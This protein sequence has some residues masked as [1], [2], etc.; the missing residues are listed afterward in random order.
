MSVPQIDVQDN[1]I[2]PT[3]MT[4][5]E[6]LTYRNLIEAM[7]FIPEPKPGEENYRTTLAMIITIHEQMKNRVTSESDLMELTQV[8]YIARKASTETKAIRLQPLLS[9]L[10]KV[11]E[12]LQPTE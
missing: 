5:D 11:L 9:V 4:K 12:R 6:V 10:D 1:S 8:D 3:T 2:H 7:S